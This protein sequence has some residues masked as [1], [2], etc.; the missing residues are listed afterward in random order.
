[1]E[2]NIYKDIDLSPN[3]YRS[4]LETIALRPKKKHFQKIVEHMFERNKE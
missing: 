3:V 2:G 4:L 1:M